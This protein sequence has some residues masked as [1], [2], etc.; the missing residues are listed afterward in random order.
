M[1]IIK[2]PL[3]WSLES[4]IELLSFCHCLEVKFSKDNWWGFIF[5][6]CWFFR[7]ELRAWFVSKDTILNCCL[8]LIL[9][10]WRYMKMRPAIAS[11]PHVG[12]I[13]KAPVIHIA[14]LHCIFFNFLRGW[15]KGTLLKYHKGNLWSTMSKTHV[16]YKSCLWEGDKPLV[17]F[18]N[19]FIPLVV[20]RALLE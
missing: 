10:R 11:I 12:E 8:L 17:E 1:K 3:R 19:I 9:S 18:S 15:N 14:A 6:E 13:W 2:R 7:R 16:L 5:F 4:T 20:K